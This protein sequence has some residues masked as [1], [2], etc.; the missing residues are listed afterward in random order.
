MTELGSSCLVLAAPEPSAI[1]P[2][3]LAQEDRLAEY[4]SEG[5]PALAGLQF[6]FLSSCLRVSS[7]AEDV[8]SLPTLETH[9]G[10]SLRRR[11]AGSHDPGE[12]APSAAPR[13]SPLLPSAHC[14]PND[15]TFDP[16]VSCQKNLYEG[17]GRRWV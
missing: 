2:L 11:R 12:G 8:K 3:N 15:P 13:C 5:P 7:W 6:H 17:P 10:T 14:L 4:V 1:E 16:E 9:V